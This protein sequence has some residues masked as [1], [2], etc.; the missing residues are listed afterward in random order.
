[1]SLKQ[2]LTSDEWTAV[3][4]G[5]MLAGLAVSAADPNGLWGMLKEGWA[6]AQNLAAGRSHT[7]AVV[8]ELVDEVMS[9]DGR[10]AIQASIK[11]R[12]AGASSG[13][14]SKIALAAMADVA[15]IIDTKIGA[16]G[17]EL[18][19]W[20]YTNA[21]RVAAAA[22]E[23]GILGFGGVQVSEN[24]KATLEELKSALKL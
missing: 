15:R 6:N 21:E 10:S 12:L 23:G 19:Q 9:A 24:E 20:L 16:N 8:K 5:V 1:M 3:R 2:S 14:V 4:D 22:S 17:V 11:Q 7:S 13:Q 18:K